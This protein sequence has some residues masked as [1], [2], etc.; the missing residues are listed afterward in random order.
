MKHIGHTLFGDVT[1]G[2]DKLL[3]GTQFSKYRAFVD[4]CFK[5]MPR[6]A[7]HAKSLGFIHP[8]TKERMQFDSELP[9]D[10]KAVME[11]WEAYVQFN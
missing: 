11:K 2:G 8:I 4:N 6:Q 5:L 7:L 1:Y 3:K 9:A 10:F